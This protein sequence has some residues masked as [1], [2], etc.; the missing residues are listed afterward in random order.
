MDLDSFRRILLLKNVI[1][2]QIVPQ[3][4]PADPPV[5]KPKIRKPT[6]EVKE[7]SISQNKSIKSVLEH[8]WVL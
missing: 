7:V 3:K 6:E 5:G 1:F 8:I 2:G 4:G